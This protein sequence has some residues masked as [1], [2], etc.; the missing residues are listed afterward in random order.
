MP[1]AIRITIGDTTL[2]AELK[3]YQ[4]AVAQ[5]PQVIVANKMDL[6]EAKKQMTRFLRH[7]KV[8]VAAISAQTGE[9][10]PALLKA[11]AKKLKRFKS[12]DE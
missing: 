8:E 2:N 6:P 5:K 10:I 9:G 12:D 3:A 7:V 1:K 11:I 4:T